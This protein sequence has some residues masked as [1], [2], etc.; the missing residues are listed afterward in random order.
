VVWS[1]FSITPVLCAD[2]SVVNVSMTPVLF[3]DCGVVNVSM[4]PVLSA[5]CSVVNVSMTPVLCR[6]WCGQRFYD[7]CVVCR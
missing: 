2:C 3:A 6:W 1:F 7:A 5:D 4:T